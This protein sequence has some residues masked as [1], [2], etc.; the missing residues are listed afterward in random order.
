MFRWRLA[1]PARLEFDGLPPQVRRTFAE[2]MDAVVFV[3]PT[4]YQQRHDE[5]DPPKDLRILYF[6]PHGEGL[7]TFL[8]YPPDDLVLVV[9]IQWLGE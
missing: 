6:G 8:L 7:V 2:F 4:D 3:D 9:K 1:P 5:P